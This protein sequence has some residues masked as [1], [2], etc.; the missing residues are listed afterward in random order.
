MSFSASA[1]DEQRI[2]T[3]KELVAQI[4]PENRY[5]EIPSGPARGKE[6]VDSQFPTSWRSSPFSS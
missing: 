6:S 5:S 4:T 1:A 2:P 3:L